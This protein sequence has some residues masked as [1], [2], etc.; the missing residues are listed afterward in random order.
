VLV[1]GGVLAARG[2]AIIRH[3]PIEA[4]Q[5]R[6]AQRDQVAA[7][8]DPVNQHVVLV[9]YTADRSPHEEW[10]YNGADIDAQDVI[11]AHDLGESR[12]GELVR[13]YKDRKIWLLEPDHED[14]HPVP[15][16]Q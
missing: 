15:Y 13:Y 5:P 2:M 4:T 9:R 10:V 14:S 3:Q 7:S 8:F 1:V 12:D 6:N 16:P 11:W